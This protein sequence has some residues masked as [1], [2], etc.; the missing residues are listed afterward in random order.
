MRVST[1]LKGQ[2]K[3]KKFSYQQGLPG[4]VWATG[5]PVVIDDLDH[6]YFEHTEE[7][8]QVGFK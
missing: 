4:T 6:S 2:A 8:H 5:Q 1:L 3:K 7:A